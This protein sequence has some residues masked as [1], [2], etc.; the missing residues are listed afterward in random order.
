MGVFRR[1]EREGGKRDFSFL[2]MPFLFILLASTIFGVGVWIW[3]TIENTKNQTVAEAFMDSF[4]ITVPGSAEY[5]GERYYYEV[6]MAFTGSS[7]DYDGILAEVRSHGIPVSSSTDRMRKDGDLHSGYVDLTIRGIDDTLST[8]AVKNILGQI[9]ALSG[10]E[11]DV[12]VMSPEMDERMAVSMAL[13]DA[14]ARGTEYL[15]DFFGL[16]GAVVVK[17]DD[18]HISYDDDTGYTSADLMLTVRAEG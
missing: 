8:D 11:L 5:R 6:S 14:K 3:S 18:I 7:L 13:D 16:A 12:Q 1:K 4:T 10:I 17:V 2:F 15:S 9:P